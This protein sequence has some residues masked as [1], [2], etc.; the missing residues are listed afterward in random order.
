ASGDAE[1]AAGGVLLLGALVRLHAWLLAGPPTELPRFVRTLPRAGA[2]RGKRLHLAWRAL[3]TIGLRVAPALVRTRSWALAALAAA[4]L[5][6]PDDLVQ[7]EG[8]TPPR[9]P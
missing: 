6:D 9:V 5:R 2:V 8:Q 1:L 7:L 3:A 4:W